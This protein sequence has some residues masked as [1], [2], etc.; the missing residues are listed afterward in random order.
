MT[1]RVAFV[2]EYPIS[3]DLVEDEEFSDRGL[4]ILMAD[5]GPRTRAA[6]IDELETAVREW[7][8]KNWKRRS[9]K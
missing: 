6:V 3:Q 5:N 2:V 7:R 8:E 4:A 9:T 1:R